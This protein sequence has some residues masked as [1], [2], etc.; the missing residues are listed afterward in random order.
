M[1]APP[2]MWPRPG[3]PREWLNVNLNPGKWLADGAMG[4]LTGAL[5]TVAG[6]ERQIVFWL[7]GREVEN[8]YVPGGQGAHAAGITGSFDV[9]SYTD[10]A[11]TYLGP[12]MAYYNT[13]QSVA[14]FLLGLAVFI[15]AGRELLHTAFGRTPFRGL[16]EIIRRFVVALA[17]ALILSWTI[18][19]ALID[20]NNLLIQI[21]SPWQFAGDAL[22][23]I[24]YNEVEDALTRAGL[25]LETA[26]MTV[27]MLFSL[28]VLTVIMLARL[29]ILNILIALGPAA[30]MAYATPETEFLFTRWFNALISVTFYQFLSMLFLGLGFRFMELAWTRSAQNPIL[31]AAVATMAAIMAIVGPPIVGFAVSR[32][33]SS[34]VTRTAKQV[35]AAVE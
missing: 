9:L 20:L 29:V 13:M 30:G 19:C 2:G 25:I 6:A 4:A 16:G 22:Q 10:P 5:E 33:A 7:A 3:D 24:M 1:T 8:P 28:L 32:A 21:F 26:L 14:A 27:V 12:G 17:L 35:V 34:T 23:N 11:L 15:T 18:S 31:L